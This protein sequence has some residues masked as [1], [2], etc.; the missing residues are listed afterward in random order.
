[1]NTYYQLVS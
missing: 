1:M